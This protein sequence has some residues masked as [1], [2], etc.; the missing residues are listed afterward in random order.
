MR[1]WGGPG[2]GLGN[3]TILNSVLAYATYL[4][5]TWLCGLKGSQ[6]NLLFIIILSLCNIILY[7]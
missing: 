2:P 6:E 5:V 1:T 7:N 4:M 3:C